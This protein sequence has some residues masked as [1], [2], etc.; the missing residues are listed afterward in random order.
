MIHL[1][2][3]TYSSYIEEVF[4]RLGKGRQQAGAFYS[5]LF[6]NGS[7]QNDD[8]KFCNAQNLV[9]EIIDMTQVDLPPVI[10]H[11]EDGKTGKFLLKTKDNLEIESVLIPMQAGVTLCVSSQVGCRMGCA[12]CETGRMG[13]LRNLTTEEIV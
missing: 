7:V 5:Q 3:H 1:L 8:P 4:L 2:S 9:K 12:F 13:L 11:R 6:R 10:D